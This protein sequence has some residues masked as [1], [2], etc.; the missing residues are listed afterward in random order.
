[1]TSNEELDGFALSAVAADEVSPEDVSTL[2]LEYRDGVAVL[3][4]TGG[5]AIPS[6]IPVVNEEGQAVAVYETTPVPAAKSLPGLFA[7]GLDSINVMTYDFFGTP[8]AEELPQ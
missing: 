1:M 3:V 8:W 6:G 4:V 7:A 5:K 2:K